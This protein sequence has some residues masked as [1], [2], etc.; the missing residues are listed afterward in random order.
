MSR[1]LVSPRLRLPVRD[2]AVQNSSAR[3]SATCTKTGSSTILTLIVLLRNAHELLAE[4]L[5]LEQ[6][7]EGRRRFLE[8]IGDVLAI[9]D[10]PFLD[11]LRHLADEVVKAAPEIRDDE[12]P[13]GE[14]L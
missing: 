5:A 14:P 7:H 9:L 3:V 11:P 10:A 6:S 8:A 4:V 2:I 1:I 12:A 13:D